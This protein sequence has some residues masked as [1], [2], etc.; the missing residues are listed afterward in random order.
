MFISKNALI[1]ILIFIPVFL[2]CIYGADI[3][4]AQLIKLWGAERANE[5]WIPGLA[6]LP[7]A[8]WVIYYSVYLYHKKWGLDFFGRKKAK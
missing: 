2:L 5:S 7:G 1:S 4:N 6:Y 8:A 3:I